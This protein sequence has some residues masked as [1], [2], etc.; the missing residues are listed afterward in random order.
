MLRVLRH[1]YDPQSLRVGRRASAQVLRE[2]WPTPEADP[3]RRHLP[4]ICTRTSISSD[5]SSH[6]VRAQP[7][8]RRSTHAQT[9][10]DGNVERSARAPSQRRRTPR[11]APRASCLQ[12]GARSCA[13]VFSPCGTRATPAPRRALRFPR[14]P[15]YQSR[16]PQREGSSPR[17]ITPALR[18]SSS[19][20]HRPKG[21]HAPAAFQHELEQQRQ[22][23][24]RRR[25]SSPASRTP[26]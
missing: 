14:F 18:M 2:P 7:A 16:T 20:A 12:R 3:A 22:M 25:A 17:R 11:A 6:L 19:P 13:S 21:A 1:P 26:A 9:P 8:A 5:S 23:G 24:R 15:Y 10:A 4:R